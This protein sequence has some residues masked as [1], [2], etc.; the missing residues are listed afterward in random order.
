MNRLTTQLHFIQGIKDAKP[1][2]TR[3]LLASAGEDLIKALVQCAI[4]SLDGNHSLSK[5]ENSTLSKYKN[6]LRVLIDPKLVSKVN[7]N[8]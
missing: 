7:G 3:A 5:E 4:K 1:Q 2:A 8:F 6:R